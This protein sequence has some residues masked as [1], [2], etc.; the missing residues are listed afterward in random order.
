M[1]SGLFYLIEI[2]LVFLYQYGTFYRLLLYILIT[3]VKL[4]TFLRK[5][6]FFGRQ[7]RHR[8]TLG[9]QR[10]A[11]RHWAFKLQGSCLN[12]GCG[13]ELWYLGLFWSCHC[14]GSTTHTLISTHCREQGS[15][16]RVKCLKK[17]MSQVLKEGRDSCGWGVA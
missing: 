15:K 17:G 9:S 5:E 3:F 12:S 11:R 1:F 7:V 13:L 4:K 14:R 16:S 10:S 2:I 6:W 8:G